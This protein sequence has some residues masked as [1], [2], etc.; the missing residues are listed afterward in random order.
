[1]AYL[2]NWYKDERNE[3]DITKEEDFRDLNIDIEA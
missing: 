2:N 1:M 3:M